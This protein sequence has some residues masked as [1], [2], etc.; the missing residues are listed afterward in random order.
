MCPLPWVTREIRTADT[1]TQEDSTRTWQLQHQTWTSC[2][3]EDLRRQGLPPA[4]RGIV[5]M[6]IWC[7]L[8]SYCCLNV[9]WIHEFSISFAFLLSF[10]P[11][12]SFFL[13][14]LDYVN[15]YASCLCTLS[16]KPSLFLNSVRSFLFLRKATF[17]CVSWHLL[18]KQNRWPV[19]NQ[20]EEE[21]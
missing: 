7:D 8:S 14:T 10:F 20:R 3:T 15:L 13:S 17:Y 5:V 4:F 18:E 2:Y 21:D 9:W 6:V 11:P 19:L 16:S 1:P 12:L